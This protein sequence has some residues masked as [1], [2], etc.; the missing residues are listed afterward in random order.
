M[1]KASEIN[2]KLKHI[3]LPDNYTREDVEKAIAESKAEGQ[4]QEN[5]QMGI[6]IFINSV[7]GAT[8]SPYFVGYNQDL[9]EAITMQGQDIIKFSSKILNKYFK[10]FWWKDKDLHAHLG[11]SQ[12]NKVMTDTIIYGDTDSC[13]KDTKLR[14]H[15]GREI[16]FEDFYNENVKNGSAGDTLMGHE[17]VNTNSKVLNWYESSGLVYEQP[18][19]VIRHKVTKPK[20]ELKTKSGEAVIITNDHSL[21]VFRDSEKLKIKP[22][23]VKKGDKI[24]KVIKT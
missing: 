21:I 14:L 19:R 1:I 7:Y 8:A 22:Q 24:L 4:R 20:W 15:D 17:S 16:S 5:K 10:D 13:H 9:A 12:P 11:I 3:Q 23:D 2:K 18:K 6:K